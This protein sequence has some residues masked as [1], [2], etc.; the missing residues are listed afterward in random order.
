MLFFAMLMDG[1]TLFS[2]KIIEN[3]SELMSGYKANSLVKEQFSKKNYE[4]LTRGDRV[5]LMNDLSRQL[6]E[7]NKEV[8]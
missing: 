5:R 3:E 1:K 6:E 7:F 2:G 8:S 4:F